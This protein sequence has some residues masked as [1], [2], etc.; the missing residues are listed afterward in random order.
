M[1]YFAYSLQITQGRIWRYNYLWFMIYIVF[2]ILTYRKNLNAFAA[3]IV[4]RH[5]SKY[6]RCIQVTIADNC[7][8]KNILF[9]RNLNML[10]F[11]NSFVNFIPLNPYK[12]WHSWNHTNLCTHI[13]NDECVCLSKLVMQLRILN[14]FNTYELRIFIFQGWYLKV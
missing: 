5:I 13:W 3:W 2:H 11:V 6:T 8:K 12:R 1:V 7:I 9:A 14:W 10:P 4:K